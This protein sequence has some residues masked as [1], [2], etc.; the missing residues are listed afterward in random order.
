MLMDGYM[1][2]GRVGVGSHKRV[3]DELFIIWFV[4]LCQAKAKEDC[5]YDD[6][7]ICWYQY[8]GVIM[9]IYEI[10]TIVPPSHHY[11]PK[12]VPGGEK[13]W[14]QSKA[15]LKKWWELH[16]IYDA[17][18]REGNWQQKIYFG[19]SSGQFVVTWAEKHNHAANKDGFEKR[20]AKTDLINA[21]VASGTYFQEL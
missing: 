11:Y 3:E 18:T 9:S 20:K 4:Y 6:M 5:W 1:L 19:F 12:D 13:P 8:I 10:I 16:R 2:T 14:L 17:A 21:I 7:L 15:D